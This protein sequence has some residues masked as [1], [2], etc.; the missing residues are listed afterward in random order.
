MS[1]GV[2]ITDLVVGDGTC[3]EKSS[4]VSV[5]LSGK[6]NRGDVFLDT[7]RQKEPMWLDL[8]SRECIAGIR[9][10]IIGMQVGGKR[11][12]IISPHLAY[13]AAGLPG[14]VPPAAVLKVT[15]ELLEV[16][17]AGA[18]VHSS[19]QRG[20]H[21]YFFWPGESAFGRPRL[22]LVLYDDG[23]CGLSLTIPFPGCTWR[24][25]RNRSI[26]QS[27]TPEETA[28]LFREIESMPQ[29]H[30]EGCRTNDDLWADPSEKANS[31]TRD[32]KT[33][34]PCVTLGISSGGEF[35]VYFSLLQDDPVFLSSR[36][37][38]QVMS[39]REELEKRAV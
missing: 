18:S 5:R 25:V 14:T 38:R 8:A 3:A 7:S 37:H 2:K 21:L 11:E 1:E 36:I 20:R 39:M 35:T 34:T 27:L 28:E 6:L 29:F 33:N 26:E 24:H 10:G 16:Q 13:G 19:L 12:L 32:G 30:P 15:V 31:V 23:R 9:Q 22:Q 17:P 4:Q